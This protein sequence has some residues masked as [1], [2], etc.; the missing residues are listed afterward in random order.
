MRALRLKMPVCLEDLGPLIRAYEE[1][2]IAGRFIAAMDCMSRPYRIHQLGLWWDGGHLTP[3]QFREALLDVWE[4]TEFPHSNRRLALRLFRAAGFATNAPE[5]WARL[6]DP[7]EIWRGT[8]HLR[9]KGLS[10][11]LDRTRALWFARRFAHGQPAHLVHG[12]ILKRH[13][14]AFCHARGEGEVV[15]DP[16]KL[17]ILGVSNAQAPQEDESYQ[18]L[19]DELR[20]RRE[21]Q[22]EAAILAGNRRSLLTQLGREIALLTPR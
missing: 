16:A 12:R 10:W 4:D 8:N 20:R 18:R 6:S 15:V 11:T 19:L 21:E 17:R 3:D 9:P 1:R 2:V 13:V 14:L 22:M 7:L 5:E